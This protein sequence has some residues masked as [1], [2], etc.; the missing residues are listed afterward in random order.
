[1]T[2]HRRVIIIIGYK[3]FLRAA[4][5][6]RPAGCVTPHVDGM[7]GVNS[8]SCSCIHIILWYKRYGNRPVS[9]GQAISFWFLLFSPPKL[10]NNIFKGSFI[11]SAKMYNNCSAVSPNPLC[12]VHVGGNTR[13]YSAKTPIIAKNIIR[14]Y[15]N[16]KTCSGVENLRPRA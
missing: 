8:S 1:M 15:I 14:R 2:A 12:G 4:I 10:L 13:R 7:A 11:V 16:P 9:A 3:G 6:I 5:L